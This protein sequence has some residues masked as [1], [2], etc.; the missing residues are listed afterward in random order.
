MITLL[1]YSVC[2]MVHSATV[3]KDWVYMKYMRTCNMGEYL[4]L[5]KSQNPSAVL[6]P[7]E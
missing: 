4:K 7:G 1:G 3:F 5:N 2:K 6:T